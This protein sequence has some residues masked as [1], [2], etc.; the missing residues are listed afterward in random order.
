MSNAI[1]GIFLL[2]LAGFMNGSFI[3]PMK[4]MRRW[5]WENAWL[6]WSVYALAVFP[7]FLVLVTVVWPREVYQQTPHSVTWIVILCGASWGISQVFFGLAIEAV[8][9]GLGFSVI[10]GISAAVGSIV[11][12]VRFHPEQIFS[13]QGLTVLGGVA[14]VL[15]GVAFC[16]FAGRRR[17]AALGQAISTRGTPVMKGLLFCLISG[18]GSALVNLGLAYGAPLIVVA[19]SLGTRAMWAPNTVW[20]PLFCAGGLPNILY[21]VHLL[22]KNRTASR[23]AQS[24]SV[25]YLVLAAVMAAFSFGSAVVYGIATGVLGSLGAVLGWPLFMSMIVIT[26]SF[27]GVATGEWKGAGTRAWRLMT[28][29]VVVLLLAVCV[30]SLA[31]R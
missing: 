27:W 21:C 14:L 15:L 20:M 16:A 3:L 10:L 22:R 9:M 2:A 24:A 4:F 18:V 5:A 29:G 13:R 12:L 31:T 25:L 11:P 8:G 19:K 26:A 6:F 7:V 1:A 23:F 30:L 28:G 17:E